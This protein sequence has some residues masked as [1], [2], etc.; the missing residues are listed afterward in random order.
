MVS[1]YTGNMVTVRFQTFVS[2]SPLRTIFNLS[3]FWWDL[4]HKQY[5]LSGHKESDVGIARQSKWHWK[6]KQTKLNQP[7]DGPAESVTSGR[8]H[9]CGAI[10]EMEVIEIEAGKGRGSSLSLWLRQDVGKKWSECILCEWVWQNISW[11]TLKILNYPVGPNLK[12]IALQYY[13]KI[14]PQRWNNYTVSV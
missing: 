4:G 9:H 10:M 5:V 13:K 14:D 12:S 2:I 11:N 3:Q 8:C 6:R 7:G 1:I